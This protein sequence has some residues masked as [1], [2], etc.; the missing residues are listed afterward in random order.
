MDG[1]RLMVEVFF[2][3]LDSNA[4]MSCRTNTSGRL[5]SSARSTN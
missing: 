4:P 3:D 2:R 5:T 1:E